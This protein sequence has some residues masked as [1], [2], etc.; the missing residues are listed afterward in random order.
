MNWECPDG[1]REEWNC[2]HVS[3]VSRT[4]NLLKTYSPW[5]LSVMT[6]QL[7]KEDKAVTI[8]FVGLPWDHGVEFAQTL[9]DSHFSK[10]LDNKSSLRLTFPWRTPRLVVTAISKADLHVW[11]KMTVS[12]MYLYVYLQSGIFAWHYTEMNKRTKSPNSLSHPLQLVCWD[13]F[14]HFP[15]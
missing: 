15:C 12:H 3:N 6:L 8:T 13:K 2:C 9:C 7:G 1:W 10:S 11:E 14:V 5:V 4:Q